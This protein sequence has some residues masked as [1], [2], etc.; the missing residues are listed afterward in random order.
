MAPLSLMP[1]RPT[2]KSRRVA[3]IQGLIS[4]GSFFCSKGMPRCIGS[5]PPAMHKSL[6]AFQSNKIVAMANFDFKVSP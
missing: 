6:E 2:Q 3:S 1:K 4:K 5:V